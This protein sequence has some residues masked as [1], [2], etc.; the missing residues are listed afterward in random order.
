[1]RGL[2]SGLCLRCR[3]VG[4]SP[5]SV[6]SAKRLGSRPSVAPGSTM[7]TRDTG[8]WCCSRVVCLR[9]GVAPV[10]GLLVPSVTAGL[11]TAAHS[12][13]RAGRPCSIDVR[14][15]IRVDGIELRTFEGSWLSRYHYVDVRNPYAGSE[16]EY[17]HEL[18]LSSRPS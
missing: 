3:V 5:G 12:M 17:V 14:G 8:S 2:C 13:I 9:S 4:A 6:R 15:C 1:M 7:A 16:L 18:N 10:S 11:V